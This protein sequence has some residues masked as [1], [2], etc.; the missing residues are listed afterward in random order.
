MPGAEKIPL[1]REIHAHHFVP[2][3][4]QECVET[5]VTSRTE[6]WSHQDES[7]IHQDKSQICPRTV[8]VRTPVDQNWH[9]AK[10]RLRPRTEINPRT[11]RTPGGPDIESG[12]SRPMRRQ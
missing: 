7:Q 8:K 10:G 9:E 4:G 3:S 11:G 6:T 5:H 12:Y 2:I 1:P